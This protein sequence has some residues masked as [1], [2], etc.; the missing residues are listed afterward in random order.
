MAITIA[1]GLNG[2]CALPAGNYAKI[3]RWEGNF[4]QDIHNITGFG[5]SGNKVF[6][7][8]LNY[9]NFTATG[10]PMFNVANSKPGYGTGLTKDPVGATTT[11]TVA[12]GC[13]YAG[14]SIIGNIRPSVDYNGEARI[15]FD[16]VFSG[17]ITE[18]WDET[19]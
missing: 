19:P 1:L 6:L 14:T 13:T 10:R 12:S 9:G 16:G 18:T 7:G 3:D 8:G 2:A 4:G 5:D 11:L 17:T 15:T